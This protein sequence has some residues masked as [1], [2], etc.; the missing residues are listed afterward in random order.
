MAKKK[1]H[2][3]LTDAQYIEAIEACGGV[4]MDVAERLGV[5]VRAVYKRRDSSEAVAK[6]IEECREEIVDLA[7]RCIK[8]RVVAGET[9]AAIFVLKTR[10]KKRGWVERHE[11]TGENGGPVRLTNLSDE[12]LIAEGARIVALRTGCSGRPEA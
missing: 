3:H 7:E 5:G 1:G 10:G 8:E 6:A 4:L 2:H 11:V 9:V 12:E